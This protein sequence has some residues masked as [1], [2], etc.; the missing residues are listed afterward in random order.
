LTIPEKIRCEGHAGVLAHGLGFDVEEFFCAEAAREAGITHEDWASQPKRLAEP[1]GRILQ[2]LDDHGVKATFFILGWVAENERSLVESI[3]SAG[4]EIAS[5]GMSHNM[6]NRLTPETFAA[7][8]LESRKLLED[9]TGKKVRGFRAPTFSI[10]HKTAWAIDVLA[11]CDYEYDSSVFPIRHDRYGVAEAP[12][13][14]HLAVGPDGGNILEIP[15]LTLR[16]LGRNF[17]AAGGGYLR[18]LG[19]RFIARAL[20]SQQRKG[21]SGVIY[22]HPWELDP[23]QPELSMS[24]ISRFRHRVNLARTES[25]LR[26]LMKQFNF[27]PMS[28]IAQSISAQKLTRFNYGSNTSQ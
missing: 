5:H 28:T 18:L 1:I 4:H 15:P 27:C 13:Q 22:L 12:P 3:A 23:G 16:I 2:M 7:E 21:Q 6:L 14:A 25:K 20:T 26:W 11:E 8:L 24:F 9:I 19:S 10:T 17:P